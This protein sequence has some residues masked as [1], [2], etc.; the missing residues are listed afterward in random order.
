MVDEAYY[1]YM[2]QM[3][4]VAGTMGHYVSGIHSEKFRVPCYER[5]KI[6]VKHKRGG[7]RCNERKDV[8]QDKRAGTVG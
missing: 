3:G 1:G 5:G 6:N 2:C 4:C 7:V 8:S